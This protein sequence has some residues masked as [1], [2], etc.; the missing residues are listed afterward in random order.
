MLREIYKNS[1]MSSTKVFKWHKRFVEGREDVEN[2]PKS[3]RPCTF[4]T[5]A[6]IEKV[7]HLVRHGQRTWDGQRNGPNHFGGRF[8]H[9]EGVCQNGAETLD[10]GAESSLSECMPRHSL[11]AGS[12][13]ANR[14]F[15]FP[16]GLPEKFPQIHAKSTNI[17]T[18]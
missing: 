14:N 8:G 17:Q 9:V 18:K 15:L 6:N 1:A 4:T 11:A 13:A 10:S 12:K 2:D 7:R 16:P 3:G 5:N